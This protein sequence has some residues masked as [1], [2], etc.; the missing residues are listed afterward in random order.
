MELDG[1]CRNPIFTVI[2]TFGTSLWSDSEERER[3]DADGR[4]GTPLGTVRRG[5]TLLPNLARPFPP[6]RALARARPRQQ[7]HALAGIRRPHEPE[8]ALGS[9]RAGPAR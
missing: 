6:R 2:C 8:G 1:P 3:R 9:H 7:L 5:E 4:R